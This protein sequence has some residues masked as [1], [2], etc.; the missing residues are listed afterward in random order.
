MLASEIRFPTAQNDT[1]DQRQRA[2]RRTGLPILPAFDSSADLLTD[3]P[4]SKPQR[5]ACRGLLYRS[6]AVL[7]A[8]KT[9]SAVSDQSER[10]GQFPQWCEHSHWLSRFRM[11]QNDLRCSLRAS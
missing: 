5:R 6:R 2:K 7:E 10:S 8:S 9:S 11:F 4:R 1:L 3:D